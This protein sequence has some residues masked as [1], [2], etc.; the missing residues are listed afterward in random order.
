M[1]NK[2]MDLKFI[3]N[4]LKPSV[5]CNVLLTNSKILDSNSDSMDMNLSNLWET[6]ED[7]GAWY[8][9]VHG[10]AK[11]WT[12]LR[13]WTM[14]IKF[15]V[16]YKSLANNCLFLFPVNICTRFKSVSS[17]NSREPLNNPWIW[18]GQ[19]A[20]FPFHRLEDWDLGTCNYVAGLLLSSNSLKITTDHPDANTKRKK[21]QKKNKNCNHQQTTDPFSSTSAEIRAH[22]GYINLCKSFLWT[23]GRKKKKNE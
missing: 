13:G 16:V 19:T 4:K 12:R 11:S 17:L 15:L 20:V 22:L 10:V 23:N 5:T 2:T 14:T 6:G 7:R 8:T 21:L 1:C 18:G 3:Y 9:A